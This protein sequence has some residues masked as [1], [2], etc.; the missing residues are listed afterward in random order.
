MKEIRM[1]SVKKL[2]AQHASNIAR[3][4]I[5]NEKIE[6]SNKLAKHHVTHAHGLSQKNLNFL[7]VKMHSKLNVSGRSRRSVMLN[8]QL[9]NRDSPEIQKIITSRQYYTFSTWRNSMRRATG[10][11]KFDC[12]IHHGS[13]RSVHTIIFKNITVITISYLV[14]HT[15]GTYF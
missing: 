8:L 12:F 14:P 4:K 11:N 15:S 7:K 10:S 5:I 13:C 3:T 6:T 9:K 2:A 1:D